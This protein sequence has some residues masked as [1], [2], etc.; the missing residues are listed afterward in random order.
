MPRRT[1][2]QQ[3]ALTAGEN[4]G[5]VGRLDARRTVAD[6]VDAPVDAKKPALLQPPLDPRR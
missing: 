6:S 4:G 1:A 5:Q 3:R 2:T